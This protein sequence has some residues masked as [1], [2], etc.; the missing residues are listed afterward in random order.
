V[1]RPPRF[2]LLWPLSGMCELADQLVWYG[3]DT[4]NQSSTL[5][6]NDVAAESDKKCST[7]NTIYVCNSKITIE[8]AVKRRNRWRHQDSTLSMAGN[9]TPRVHRWAST[10]RRVGRFDASTDRQLSMRSFASAIKHTIKH[11][12]KKRPMNCV[13]ELK[14]ETNKNTITPP[15]R[16]RGW[17]KLQSHTEARQL[18]LVNSQQQ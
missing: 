12:I 18:S 10:C 5:K 15:S 17:S 6:Q 13:H 2:P 8:R 16:V 7:V 14:L 11:V 4:I 1:P 3:L 9:S